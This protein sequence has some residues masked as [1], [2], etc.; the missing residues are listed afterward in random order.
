MYIAYVLEESIRRKLLASDRYAPRYN[1][2]YAHHITYKF[3]VKKNAELPVQPKCVRIIGHADS[4][5]G[6][7]AYA[8]TVDGRHV[9]ED[10]SVFHITWS[11]D[12]ESAYKPKD[13]NALL[14][15][16]F[17]LVTPLEIEV[18]P[19]LLR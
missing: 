2:P 11:I 19:E 18:T 14:L 17:N 8:V 12:K 7:E 5:D 16:G 10:G 3:G 9:R 15:N 1:N 13:S 4:G 6:I